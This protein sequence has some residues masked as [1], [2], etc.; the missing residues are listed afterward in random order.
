[1]GSGVSGAAL[2]SVTSVLWLVAGVGILCAGLAILLISRFPHL[3]RP[4]ALAAT[5]AGMLSFVIFWDGQTAEFVNQGGIGLIL[6][7]V[8]FV[9]ALAFPGSIAPSG[10]L[11]RTG[12]G[13]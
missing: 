10:G 5:I 13:S 6:S 7:A 8:I 12:E 9:G 11:Q 4:L 3:W 2:K 1:M